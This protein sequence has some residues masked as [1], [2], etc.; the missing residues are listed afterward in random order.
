M[1]TNERVLNYAT[2]PLR[3]RFCAGLGLAALI[4]CYLLGYASYRA[5]GP[6][7]KH[8]PRGGGAPG[9]L[10]SLESPSRVALFQLFR[11]CIAVEDWWYR[12][13]YRA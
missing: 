12:C 7:E 2:V 11:P 10:I 9:L 1:P 5:W 4:V 6:V 3:R 8:Y 13:T